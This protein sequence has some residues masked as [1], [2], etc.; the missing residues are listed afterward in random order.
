MLCMMRTY[1]D[2]GSAVDAELF[3]DPGFSILH[4]DGL[5]G[6]ALDAIDA[7]FAQSH[8]D[9]AVYRRAVSSRFTD[10][11]PVVKQP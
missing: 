5:G 10:Q 3:V 1:S 11:S 6:A 7:A 4:A 9:L 2:T 8:W